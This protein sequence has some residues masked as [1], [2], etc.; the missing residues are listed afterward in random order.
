[1][2]GGQ[3]RQSFKLPVPTL[4][5]R[6]TVKQADNS[7]FISMRWLFH[8]ALKRSETDRNNGEP[9]GSNAARSRARVFADK[10]HMFEPGT[11]YE[12]E[13]TETASNG[14]TYRN[15]NR[16]TAVAPGRI[17]RP[18]A[19]PH[20]ERSVMSALGPPGSSTPFSRRGIRR[21]AFRTRGIGPQRY[22]RLGPDAGAAFAPAD[23]PLARLVGSF[24]TATAQDR[25]ASNYLTFESS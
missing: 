3:S 6:E 13:C 23:V 14:V 7:L 22:S 9:A 19:W 10:L 16:A 24:S 21:P 11:T 18:T 17:Q 2:N 12:I 20:P 8:A 25:G 5:N 1:L 15:V 4:K